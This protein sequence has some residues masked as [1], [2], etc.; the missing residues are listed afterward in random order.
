[1]GQALPISDSLS[2]AICDTAKN[3]D[4][5][6]FGHPR[7]EWASNVALHHGKSVGGS[8][9]GTSGILYAKQHKRRLHF[10][11]PCGN[12]DFASSYG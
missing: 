10:V 9:C 4:D 7:V 5:V 6:F 2:P 1:M 11:I 3:L 12:V 8:G